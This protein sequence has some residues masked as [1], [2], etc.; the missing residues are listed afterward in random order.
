MKS[1]LRAAILLFILVCLPALAGA[2]DW[3]RDGDAYGDRGYHCEIREIVLAADRSLIEVDAGVNGGISVVGWNRDE[4][5]IEAKVAAHAHTDAEAA[6]VV[7]GIEIHTDGEIHA[8]H[9]GRNQSWR[10]N[11]WWVSYRLHVPRRSNVDLEAHNGG[12]SIEGVTGDLTFDTTN[13]GIGLKDVGGDVRG[14][15]TNGGVRVELSGDRWEGA[16]LDVETTNGGVKVLVPD[17]YNARLETGTTNGGLEVDFPLTL[18]GKIGRKI[19]VDLGSGGKTLRVMTTNGG[20]RI[21]RG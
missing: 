14:E 5:L 6:E 2:S 9:Q 19:E 11:A 12:I 1:I 21:D 13:G 15:T 8:T 20:V 18:Q 3:C 17:G 10:G 16:G 4:I 7:A